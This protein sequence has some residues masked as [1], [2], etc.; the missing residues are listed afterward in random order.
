MNESTFERSRF[1]VVMRGYDRGQ[2]DAIMEACERWAGEAQAHMDGAQEKLAEADRRAAALEGRLSE[3]EDRSGEPPRSVQVLTERADTVLGR[4]WEAADELRTT[5]QAEARAD[6][7]GA[8]RDA[9]QLRQ[10]ARTKADEIAAEAR[11]HQEKA[12]PS[13]QA[14][15][16]QAERHIEEGR[17]EAAERARAV[18]QRAEGPISEVRRELARLEDQQQATLEELAGLRR[19][20][21]GLVQVS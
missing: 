9:T 14:V 2:V 19:S 18:W 17:A 13:T 16:R 11:R 12:T 10:A 8:E 3:L 15:R 21:D 1:A 6:K 7:E 4:A 20:L 5:V